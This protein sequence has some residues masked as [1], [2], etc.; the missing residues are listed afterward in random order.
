[1]P[2]ICPALFSRSSLRAG[3]AS[4]GRCQSQLDLYRVFKKYI[5]K[6][7]KKTK[8]HGGVGGSE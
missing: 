2:G 4:A 5:S 6:Q 3:P 1:M 8:N 7:A